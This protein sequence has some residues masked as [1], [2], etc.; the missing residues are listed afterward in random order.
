MFAVTR[1][2]AGSAGDRN[3]CLH[4]SRYKLRETLNVVRTWSTNK[5]KLTR[6]LPGGDSFG[7]HPSASVPFVDKH[8]EDVE[9]P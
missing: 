5:R 3:L 1:I 4:D 7:N 9:V 6:K 2:N 8:S